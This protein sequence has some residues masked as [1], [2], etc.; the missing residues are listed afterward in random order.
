MTRPV[1]THGA[2]PAC[3]P[4]GNTMPQYTDTTIAIRRS[5][6]SD[7][8]RSRPGIVGANLACVPT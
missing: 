1:N 6:Q 2:R 8:A 7:A 5:R 4:H 3:A